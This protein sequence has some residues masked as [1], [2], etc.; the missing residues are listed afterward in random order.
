MVRSGVGH[1]A[2]AEG[3]RLE[4]EARPLHRGG[5]AGVARDVEDDLGFVQ[6]RVHGVV[7]AQV[8]EDDVGI[9]YLLVTAVG[10][11]DDDHPPAE[12]A[13]CAYQ[14]TADESEPAGH[15]DHVRG[16]HQIGRCERLGDLFCLDVHAVSCGVRR[17]KADVAAGH[18]GR[19]LRLR[20]WV[21]AQ[22][23]TD[24]RR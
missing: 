5:P 1:V 10:D 15:G 16:E 13:Q 3:V 2:G 23:R 12:S 4:V 17:A 19:V 8:G 7:V 18:G 9:G 6:R 22:A 21:D 24:E 11:V 20:R 14:V